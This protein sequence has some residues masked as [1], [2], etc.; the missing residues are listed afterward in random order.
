MEKGVNIRD[1]KATENTNPYAGI[2]L[3]G[4]TRNE[5]KKINIIGDTHANQRIVYG[6]PKAGRYYVL[7][8]STYDDMNKDHVT[9]KISTLVKGDLG[10]DKDAGDHLS[11][12]LP[13]QVQRYPKNYLG[14]ADTVDVFSFTAKK[15]E[16]YFIGLIPNEEISSYFKLNV[17]D[18]YKQRLLTQS[19]GS[20]QGLKS[21]SFTIPEDGTY[22]IELG[23][24]TSQRRLASYTI[25]LKRATATPPSQN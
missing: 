15:G 10:T 1:G 5:L 13:I 7:M 14:S 16:V 24:G 20:N 11:K 9:F 22:F 21:R 4:D 17:Y 8:G 12:A 19:S 23:F 6:V 25:E 2:Q 18:A 3:H